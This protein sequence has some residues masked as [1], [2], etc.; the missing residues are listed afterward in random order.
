MKGGNTPPIGVK[1]SFK[2]AGKSVYEELKIFILYNNKFAQ[3][4]RRNVINKFL[5]LV[6]IL[7]LF[8]V[9]MVWWGQ[10]PLQDLVY[11]CPN[12]ND[13]ANKCTKIRSPEISL[14]VMKDESYEVGETWAALPTTGLCK[15]TGCT[16]EDCCERTDSTLPGAKCHIDIQCQKGS[17]CGDNNCGNFK[18]DDGDYYNPQASKLELDSSNCC[19]KND[20]TCYKNMEVPL[21]STFV[22]D[23]EAT[24]VG[25]KGMLVDLDDGVG[26]TNKVVDL[27]VSV[28]NLAVD[29]KD[30]LAAKV[31]NIG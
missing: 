16:M 24:A 10:E 17:E 6:I 4:Y 2:Y 8:V 13:A 22:D 30:G 1:K 5:T 12:T 26:G 11:K 29:A 20:A 28:K 21:P 18:K 9:L 19:C 23:A 14:N 31:N 7:W 3:F 27:G 25:G 15:Q